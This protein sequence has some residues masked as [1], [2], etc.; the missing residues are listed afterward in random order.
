M[1]QSS[2]APWQMTWLRGPFPEAEVSSR[3]WASQSRGCHLIVPYC[4]GS[5]ALSWGT[6]L[7][8]RRSDIPAS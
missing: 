4:A 7:V 2:S 1:A 5:V 3:H 6:H 8:S